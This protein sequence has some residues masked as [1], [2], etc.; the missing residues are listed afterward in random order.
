MAQVDSESEPEPRGVLASRILAMPADTNP[1]GNIFGGWIMSLMDAAAAMSAT[2]LADGSVV[3]VAV[4]R[5]TFMQPV[6]VGDVVC[7]YTE[8]TRTGRMSV[9]L[10]VEVWVL[11]ECRGRREKVTEAEFTFVAVDASG[12]PRP[13]AG[14]LPVEQARSGDAG[15]RA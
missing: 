11:R 2:Q 8:V 10:A 12:R 9:E 4:S 3:T 14:G 13:L 7:C 5:I 6:R 1:S 15:G